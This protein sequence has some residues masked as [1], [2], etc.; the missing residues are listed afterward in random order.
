MASYLKDKK[1]EL[2]RVDESMTNKNGF[3]IVQETK[4]ASLWAYYR[5]SSAKELYEAKGIQ[6]EYEAV[7]IINHRTDIDSRS[8][9]ILF[10]GQKYDIVS[11]DDYQGG[12]GDMKL[13]AKLRK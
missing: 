2:W 7:F 3:P 13:I 11:I 1:I 9:Y 5:H 4:I 10:R 8:D 6:E 12:K